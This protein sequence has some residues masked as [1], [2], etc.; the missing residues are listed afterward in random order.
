MRNAIAGSP[1]LRAG[2]LP[3]LALAGCG[4]SAVVLEPQGPVTAPADAVAAAE[5]GSLPIALPITRLAVSRDRAPGAAAGS[6]RIAALPTPGSLR[7]RARPYQDL[8]S[9]NV[10]AISTLENTAIPLTVGNTFTD[11]TVTRINQIGSVVATGLRL[12]GG[13]LS[14][15][16]VTPPARQ[17]GPC[18]AVALPDFYIDLAGPAMIGAE[19]RSVPDSGDCY[20]WSVTRAG[21]PVTAD[22]S[23]T[24]VEFAALLQQPQARKAAYWPVPTC[25]SVRLEIR[26]SRAATP[27]VLATLTVIDPDRVQLFPLPEEGTLALHPVCG[28]DVTNKPVD[29]WS[30]AFGALSALDAQIQAIGKAAQ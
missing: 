14:A 28:A 6:Y 12:G 3:L 29:R 30:S 13:L 26:G 27:D 1:G 9:R 24:R 7:F 16:R 11:Q 5:Q 22:G 25:M 17:Q 2:L 4:Q 18:A 19:P 23:I 21:P 8:A 10:L 20:R 15:D